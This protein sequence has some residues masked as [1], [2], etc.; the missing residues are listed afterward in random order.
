MEKKEIDVVKGKIAKLIAL[1]GSPNVHEAFAA[2]EKAKALM[3]EYNLTENKVM[4]THDAFPLDTQ[5]EKQLF[6]GV[7]RANNCF[8]LNC[9]NEQRVYGREANIFL[10]KSMFEYLRD[11]IV[12]YAKCAC[13]SRRE[14][15]EFK[16]GM[17]LTLCERLKV[18]PSW[19][20]D[21]KEV[22][23]IKDYARSIGATWHN[24]HSRSLSSN[25]L[26][27][28]F[29]AGLSLNRQASYSGGG[30]RRLS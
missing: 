22:E 13:E 24:G 2:M 28:S 11:S 20:V 1:A 4:F 21:A 10:A 26:G 27:R 3:A 8:V 15:M 7:F 29:G 14:S 16:N 30:Q 5:W 9:A 6:G 12:R 18:E 25:E 23:N 19:A 17:T